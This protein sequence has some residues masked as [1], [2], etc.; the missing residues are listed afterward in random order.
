MC[1]CRAQRHDDWEVVGVAVVFNV[2]FLQ[3]LLMF[4]QRV[5][6][7]VAKRLVFILV[8]TYLFFDKNLVR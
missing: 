4:V 2:I 5:N 3:N 8:L 6:M 7:L 1:M